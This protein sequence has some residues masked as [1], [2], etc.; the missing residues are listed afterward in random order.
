MGVV[1]RNETL[2]SRVVV[3]KFVVYLYESKTPE[4]IFLA[5]LKLVLNPTS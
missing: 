1:E 3:Y 2:K 5:C 4:T